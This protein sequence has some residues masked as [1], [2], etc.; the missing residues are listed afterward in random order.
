MIS[1]FEVVDAGL[2]TTVQDRGRPGFAHLGVPRSGALDQAALRAA[3]RLVG[4]STDAAGLE[5]TLT[6]CALRALGTQ[7]VAVTGAFA[8]IDVD[9]RPMP[10][11]ARLVVPHGTLLTIG[12]ALHGVR[13]VLAVAGGI[14]LPTVLGSRSRDTL[15]ALGPDPLRI[16]DRVPAESGR[17]PPAEDAEV[18][19]QPASHRIRMIPGPHR[20]W[21]DPE[22]LASSW[23]VAADSDRVGI[24]LD[25]TPLDRT[26]G[27]VTPF[28][29][30]LGAVQVPPSGLPVVLL[31]DHATTGGY[32]VVAVIAP[33]DLDS[34]AQWRP[35][36]RVTLDW[37]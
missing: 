27:E 6:G 34:C 36:D 3:N 20:G 1:G 33:E 31:A 13:C 2:L 23:D 22:R 11:G 16:G 4:N 19:F 14:Q 12:P 37:R 25:G 10:W 26:P 30:V 8:S 9:G 32:P 17:P 28:A 7:V 21:C 24:R 15:S 5:T 29:M 18:S 35:G